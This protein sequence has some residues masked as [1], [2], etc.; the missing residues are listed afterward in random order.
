[1]NTRKQLK[2]LG[3]QPIKGQHFLTSEPVIE[4]LVEAGEVDDEEVLEIGAGTG[5]VTEAL[6]ERASKVYAVEK[7]RKLA[8]HLKDK[9]SDQENV[10]VIEGDVLELELPD[11]T[12]C[13]SNLP[14]QISSKIVDLLGE[15][16]VHS[17]LIV[18]KDF[19]EKIVA[20]P[21]SSEYGFTAVKT[22]YYF[23]PV[24][25]RDVAPSK[26]HPRPEVDTSILKLYPNKERHGIEDEELFFKFAKALFTHDRKKVRNAFVDA[27]HMLDLEKE[28]AKKAR[29]KLP[30]SEKRVIDL[31]VKDI[32]EVVTTFQELDD[33][34]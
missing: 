31:T 11:Y 25:L 19:A 28:E 13:V 33:L 30:H 10:E 12:R 23:V 15:E 34:N 9:F 1:M 8:R 4:A 18:Q 16:Q 5:V 14:F 20:E 3:I 21:G 6:A 2:K 24:K 17:S 29:D 27:R 7:D 26:Y 32:Q 22:N